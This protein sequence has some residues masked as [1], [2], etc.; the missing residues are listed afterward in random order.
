MGVRAFRRGDEVRA[1]AMRQWNCR[2]WRTGLSG[3]DRAA[4]AGTRLVGAAAC[5]GCPRRWWGRDRFVAKRLS[6]VT[7]KRGLLLF[8]ATWQTIVVATNV[9]EALRAL[10]VLPAGWHFASGNWGFLV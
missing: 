9:F 6:V 5:A 8:W 4:A 3:S 7:L 1:A 10:G 2:E